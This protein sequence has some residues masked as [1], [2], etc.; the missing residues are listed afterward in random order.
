[1]TEVLGIVVLYDGQHGT[2][3]LIV[4]LKNNYA[5][6]MD[7]HVTLDVEAHDG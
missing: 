4:S 6:K 2:T 5:E 7:I 3:D 1:M